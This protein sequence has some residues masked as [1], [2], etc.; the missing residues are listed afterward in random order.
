LRSPWRFAFDRVNW[1]K[2]D[3][4]VY[5][6]QQ[7]ILSPYVAK[8]DIWVTP[9]YDYMHMSED[10]NTS[11][12]H[13]TRVSFMAGYDRALSKYSAA[14]F[15]FG[16]SQ[17]KL[18]QVYSRVIADDYLFGLHYDTR[19]ANDFELKLWGSYGIQ[20]YRLSRNVPIGDGE[21]VSARYKGNS[22]TASVQVSRPYSFFK[23]VIRPLAA[24]DYS[25]V[26]QSEA[27]EL[28][29]PPIALRYASSDWSQL[30]GRLGVRGD[31]GWK[32]ISLTSSLSYSYQ[33]AGQV[34]PEASN[35]FIYGDP[36]PANPIF[37]IKG[38]DLS[39]TFINVGLGS[40]IYL[41]RLKSRMFFV[42]YNGNYGKRTNAQN[43]SIGYQMTF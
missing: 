13:T 15:I 41:N 35:Q 18:E 14:G 32:R 26:K 29:Y 39:R 5:F 28:G 22:A 20:H 33:V 38:P 42:Q 4:H 36:D 12:A 37:D 23:G 43:A 31:F 6:G 10:G 16:Y 9:Y 11:G 25:F 30:F 8:Q 1:R 40:Q 24:L 3:N 7:N 27:E 21:D 19:I 34:A 2:R 17:P